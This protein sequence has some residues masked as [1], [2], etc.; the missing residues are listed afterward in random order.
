MKFS[1]LLSLA[2]AVVALPSNAPK[3]LS[4]NVKLEDE[5]TPQLTWFSASS[6]IDMVFTG[7]YTIDLKFGSQ[8]DA[9]KAQLDTGSSDLWVDRAYHNASESKDAKK[10]KGELDIV[11]G[12]TNS[13][14]GP[15]VLD[16]V[17]LGDTKVSDVQLAVVDASKFPN[18]KALLGVGRKAGEA[19]NDKY[20]NFPYALKNNG[21][22]KRA[23]F[24]L[25]LN[26]RQAKQGN[27]L[28]G[29]IDHAKI[30][31]ELVKLNSPM[32]KSAHPWVP[33]K[34]F[35]VNGVSHDAQTD[36]LL[37]S[38]ST[39]CIMKPEIVDEIAKLYTGATAAGGTYYVDC[40]Q[41]PSKFFE[42][43]FDGITIKVPIS[44]FIL[45]Q[46]GRCRVGALKFSKLSKYEVLGATFLQN[47]YAV[48]D[49]EEN[50]ISLAPARFTDETDIREI[51]AVG[52]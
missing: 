27:I 38:G 21:I 17:Y 28:F 3:V 47:V 25:Y 51:E 43:V 23:A 40:D 9:V 11:Y 14:K 36:Y 1:I 7:T 52:K 16:S 42:V 24:S 41:D 19:T 4:L 49:W 35:K 5:Q 37:D 2:A 33:T 18:H 50:T 6:D 34:A 10:L 44:Q 26:K 15:W 8:Q 31:G 45:E 30:D 39:L 46:N 48:F 29:G 32:T 12:G 20:D 22:T 13:I